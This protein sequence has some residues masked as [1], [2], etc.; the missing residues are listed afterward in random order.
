MWLQN[1]GQSEQERKS[2][3]ISDIQIT[4]MSVPAPVRSCKERSELRC[5][6]RPATQELLRCR[7][8]EL[9]IIR[10]DPTT[11]SVIVFAASYK[12]PSC[13][14]PKWHSGSI[15]INMQLLEH[16]P[17]RCEWGHKS[18][19]PTLAQRLHHI[20][21]WPDLNSSWTSPLKY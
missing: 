2:S 20:R 14:R 8:T 15:K 4:G 18:I 21:M 11:P 19:V 16:S 12:S 7:S 3:S 1:T 10:V 9:T 13:S 5:S 17:C 6:G